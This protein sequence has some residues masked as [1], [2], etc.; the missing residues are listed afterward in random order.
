MYHSRG[1]LHP[2]DAPRLIRQYHDEDETRER[3]LESEPGRQRAARLTHCHHHYRTT[4][5]L[6]RLGCIGVQ[7]SK[8]AGGVTKSIMSGGLAHESEYAYWPFATPTRPSSTDKVRRP[9]VGFAIAAAAIAAALQ[10][11]LQLHMPGI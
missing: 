11:Q 6:V 7:A 3:R 9:I 1:C 5:H 2:R 10:L 8:Q 4:R